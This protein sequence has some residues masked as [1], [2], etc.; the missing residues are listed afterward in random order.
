MPVSD[1][2]YPIGASTNSVGEASK[3]GNFDSWGVGE[4]SF[5]DGLTESCAE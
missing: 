4:A 2:S 5:G 3:M 1:L